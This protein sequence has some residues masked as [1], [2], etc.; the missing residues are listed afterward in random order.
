MQFEALDIFGR[1]HLVDDSYLFFR[2][3]AYA[4]FIK[5][6]KTLVLKT[7]ATGKWQL[8]GGGVDLNETIEQGLR[9]EIKEELG[10]DVKIEKFIHFYQSN[11][12]NGPEAWD[13]YRYFFLCSSDQYLLLS[14][15]K[16]VEDEQAFD[17]TWVKV[18][19]LNE[20]NFQYPQFGILPVIQKLGRE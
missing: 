13:C 6:G 17:P 12:Y 19:E 16:I 2:P 8:A 14:E 3:T 5:N 11:Y 15:H 7:K 10:I 9:R 18:D 4:V 1:K 20:G